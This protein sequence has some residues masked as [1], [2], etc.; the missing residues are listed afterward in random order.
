MAD[1]GKYLNIKTANTDVIYDPGKKIKFG[2]GHIY[3]DSDTDNISQFTFDVTYKINEGWSLGKGWT[4]R[5]YERFDT[6]EAKWQE[7]EYT[8]YKDLHC[9]LGEFTVNIKEGEW[10]FWVMF[11]IK[12]FPDLP[13]GLKRT[14]N[15]PSPGSTR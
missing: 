14:Y 7:Q 6:H 9:W 3:E 4:I 15:R 13:I 2:I 12:A 1:P 11:R 8:I 10:S 5:A